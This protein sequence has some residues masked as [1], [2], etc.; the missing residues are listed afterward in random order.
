MAEQETVSVIMP[1]KNGEKFIVDALRSIQQ[2]SSP[3]S[4]IFVVND[5]SE[6]TTRELVSKVAIQD[7]R[8]LLL[9]G[10]CKGP[11]PARNVGL[12]QATGDI[13]AFLDCDDMWPSGKLEMQLDRLRKE[14]KVRMV[15][16]F[17][18]YFDL[19]VEDGLEPAKEARTEEIFHV[20]LGA[21][22][23]RKDVFD[24]VGIFDETFLYSED[25]DLMLRIREADIPFTI[26]NEITLYYR[27]HDN[28]MTTYVTDEEKRDFNRAL[29]NSLRR[30]KAAGRT[31]P[32]EPFSRRVGY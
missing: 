11:G 13:I 17:V 15:S 2:Q 32:L 24:E 21:S 7:N 16:G 29:L 3:I 14:P 5:G 31:E 23:Y 22:I 12:R 9:D 30:R 19:Q 4:Q 20:H 25:V 28:S 8:V 26:M 18:K 6:D 27:R 10:P 1:V